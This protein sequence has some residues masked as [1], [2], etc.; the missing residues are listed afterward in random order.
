[1]AKRKVSAY[2]KKLGTF[3]KKGMTWKRAHAA[4]RKALGTRKSSNPK[5]KKSKTTKKSGSKRMAKKK[6]TN[7]KR[8]FTIPAA[9]VSGVALGFVIKPD[10]TWDSPYEAVKRGN[11]DI[12]VKNYATNMIG[13]RAD[14]GAIFDTTI[15]MKGLWAL[16]GGFVIHKLATVLGLNRALG[17]ARIPFL[18]V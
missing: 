16:I 8:N 2:H 11:F 15:G 9:L 4:T 5:S 14:T 12:A 18:R 3:I 6:K 1:M 7:R 17:R 10:P 13:Y